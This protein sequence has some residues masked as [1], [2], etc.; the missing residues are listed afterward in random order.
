MMKDN[1]STKTLKGIAVFFF[2]ITLIISLSFPV[3]NSI[4][5]YLFVFALLYWQRKRMQNFT[6]R[7]DN[8]RTKALVFL[9]IGWFGAVFLEFNLSSLPFSPRPLANIFI[10]AG[11]YLP[12]FILWLIL[13][14]RYRFNFLEV[15]YLSG[16]SKL[17]IDALV[18]QKLFASFTST[19]GPGLAVVSVILQIIATVA[20]MGAL[21][22]LPMLLLA[23]EQNSKHEKPLKQ[24]LLGL[25]PGLVSI[26]TF[27]LWVTI[28][29]SLFT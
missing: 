5:L 4:Y 29:K 8:L 7:V 17:L 28:L 14:K 24:Y 21:T 16:L 18:T 10:G 20:V 6:G 11:Y 25:T 23:T 22:T 3:S 27:I 15:F 19:S 9:L 13:L 2:L 26:G 12:Y 1:L